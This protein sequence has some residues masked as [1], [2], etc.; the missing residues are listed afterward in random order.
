MRTSRSSI[1]GGG[2]LLSWPF[3]VVFCYAL[4]LW[5][6][7]LVAFWLKEAF[8]LKVVFCYG[9]LVY[10]SGMAFW[11]GAFCYGL[12]VERLKPQKTIPEGCLQSE[13]HQARRP[14]NQKATQ[15]E[16]HN[17]RP[18]PPDQAPPWEQTPLEADPLGADTPLWTEFLTHTYE[19][20]TLHQTLF[21][22]GK[23]AYIGAVF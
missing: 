9:F 17:R 10:P 23:K 22:G 1:G 20:I 15:L 3:V 13:N 5:P 6:S 19:N 14:P 8:W 18:H 4:L 12:L 7:G 16:G 21:A 2:G 11:G